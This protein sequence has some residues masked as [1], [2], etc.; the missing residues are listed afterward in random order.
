MNNSTQGSTKDEEEDK[1]R[2]YEIGKGTA[3]WGVEGGRGAARSV[4]AS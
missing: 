4:T 1:S 2:L 3:H